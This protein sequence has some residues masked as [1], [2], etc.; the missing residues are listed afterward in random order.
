MRM[1]R[2][3]HLSDRLAA[4]SDLLFISDHEDRNF[5]TAILKKEYIDTNKWFG[6][7]APVYLEIGCGK[8]RFAVEFAKR[9]PDVNLIAVE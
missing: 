4:V 9:R 3:K 5:N 6:N 8:G 2:K 7:D 1:R